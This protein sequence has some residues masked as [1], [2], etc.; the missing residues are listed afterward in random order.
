MVEFLTEI[1]WWVVLLAAFAY[2]ALGA[3]WFTPLFG[4]AWDRSIGH[5]RSANQGRFPLSYYLVPFWAA[6]VATA[7]VAGLIAAVGVEAVAGGAG[8]GA[9]LGAGVG[10]GVGIAVAAATFTNSLTPHTPRPYQLACINGGYHLVGLTMAGAIL[11]MF[12]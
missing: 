5:D 7:G 6:A 10:A 4:R 2:F 9:A 1:H 12:R 8:L 11:G 3:A